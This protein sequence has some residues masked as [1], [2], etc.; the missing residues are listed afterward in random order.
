MS[1]ELESVMRSLPVKKSSGQDGFTGKFYQMFKEELIP[2][3]LKLFPSIEDK[4]TL[5]NSFTRPALHWHQ[6]QQ[7]NH[8]QKKYQLTSLMNIVAKII[9]KILANQDQ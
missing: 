4:G 9:N 2:T 3:L 5:P 7:G 8:T 1:K 6:S